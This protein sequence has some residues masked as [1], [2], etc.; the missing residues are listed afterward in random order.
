MDN[1]FGYGCALAGVITCVVIICG[2][3]GIYIKTL[4]CILIGDDSSPDTPHGP[5][6]AYK[7]YFFRKAFAD[8]RE[9][10]SES[11]EPTF[12]FAG[13]IFEFGGKASSDGCCCFIGFGVI[14]GAIAGC[15]VG[16]VAYVFF[17]IIHLAIVITTCAVAVLLAYFCRFIEYFSMAWRRIFLVCPSCYQRIALPI[18][19]CPECGA[20]H[21]RLLPGSYGTFHRRCGCDKKKLPTLFFLGRNRLPSLCPHCHRPLNE[22]IGVV[23]NIHVP[24]VGGPTA[25]K[26]SL[27]MAIIVDLERQSA[28][29]Q[30]ALEFPQ[31]KDARLFEVCKEGFSQGQLVAKTAEYS[32][33]AFQVRLKD[34]RRKESLLY[35]YDAAGELYRDSEELNRHEYYSY[36][37]TIIFVI[38]PF[39]LPGVIDHFGKHL[40]GFYDGIKPSP[41]APIDVYGRMVQFIRRFTENTGRLNVPL[42]VVLT[43]IDALGTLRPG[44]G[45]MDIKSKPIRRWLEEYGEG[46]LVRSIKQD[47]KVHRYFTC[48]ALGRIPD[49][50]PFAF[51]PSGVLTP[52]SWG[53]HKV[54]IK[55]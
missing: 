41:E 34:R 28:A 31:A 4:F 54:G 47:F 17:G 8:Y 20:E 55:L 13:T 37:H 33:D 1:I 25:G 12:E 5:E 16:F 30:L 2:V 26:T 48:S 27:L 19:V 10:V 42:A 38:D 52:L 35:V 11:L 15:V 24:V 23:R 7:Q 40:G 22:S 9:I 36:L 44:G 50:S 14:L 46:N 51:A 6:P 49:G 32:P 3:L 45:D 29:G 53:L 39:S 18:Y 21:K 43:K